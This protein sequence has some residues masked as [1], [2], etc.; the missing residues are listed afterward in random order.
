MTRGVAKPLWIPPCKWF[1][2]HT[3]IF[4]LNAT[5]R[6]VLVQLERNGYPKK[7]T[8]K[9]FSNIFHA[10]VT[11]KLKDINY[12]YFENNLFFN[13]RKYNSLKT[14]NITHWRTLCPH[15]G[16]EVEGLQVLLYL[17]SQSNFKKT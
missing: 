8:S 3:L 6:H 7:F 9:I 13:R 16:M 10:N 17:H 12:E 14:S 2:Y 11:Q 5:S 15:H 4:K 1:E